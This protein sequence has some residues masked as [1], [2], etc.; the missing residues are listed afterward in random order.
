MIKQPAKIALLVVPLLMGL[1][2]DGAASAQEVARVGHLKTDS[3][4][5]LYLERFQDQFAD[6]TPVAR[7]EASAGDGFVRVSRWA[8]DGCRGESTLLHVGSALPQSGAS[9]LWIASSAVIDLFDCK[10]TGCA[11]RFSKPGQTVAICGSVSGAT[12]KCIETNL[13]GDNVTIHMDQGYCRLAFN[14]IA[15]GSLAEWIRPGFIN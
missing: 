10:D 14:S 5:V 9:S 3:S 13:S 4:V 1:A 6:G 8:A 7:I 12:C 2:V 15:L 11:Q